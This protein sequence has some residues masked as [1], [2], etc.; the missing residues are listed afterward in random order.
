MDAASIIADAVSF[1]YKAPVLE[2]LTLTVAP[3]EAVAVLGR[4]GAGKTTFLR[5]LAGELNPKEGRI[6]ICGGDPR[7]ADVRRKLGFVGEHPAAPGFLTASEYLRYAAD[8]HGKKLSHDV[9]KAALL[10]TGV[11]EL[12][13]VRVS[14]MSKGQV[15]RVELA[16]LVAVDPPVWI[17]DEADSGI[18]PGGGRVFLSVLE[19]ARLKGRCLV[20]ATHVVGHALRLATK[21]L[22]IEGHHASWQGNATELASRVGVHGFLVRDGADSAAIQDRARSVGLSLEPCGIPEVELEAWLYPDA[23]RRES[24]T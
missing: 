24:T 10:R 13:R 15:R 19:E 21:I 9:V 16:A 22:L 20:V 6:R 8:L 14:N 12:E 5:L 23:P 7:S 2:G 1:S 11:Q 4:N 3:G 18:D 17:L